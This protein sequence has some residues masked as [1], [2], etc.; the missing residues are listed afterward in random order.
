VI[1]IDFS[2]IIIDFLVMAKKIIS[3]TLLMSILV[4][5]NG[6]ISFHDSHRK[7]LYQYIKAASVEILVDGHLEGSGWFANPD[8]YVTTAAHAVNRTNTSIEIISGNKGRLPA[9]VIASDRGHDIALLKV[10]GGTG[11]FQFLK[12]ADSIPAPED[13]VYLYGSALFH[14]GIMLGG[15]VARDGTTFTYYTDRQMLVRCYHVTA[16]SPPGTSGGPWVDRRG[17]VVGNQ[18][19]FITHHGSGAGIALVAPPDAIVRLV[20]TRKSVSTPSLGCGLEELWTQSPGFIKR[21]PK[22]FM[23]QLTKEEFET[24]CSSLGIAN[25]TTVAANN[26]QILRINSRQ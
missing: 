17:R 24:L 18:S 12:I 6:C 7:N 14:H 19:G 23:F 11:P 20:T 13:P 9:E 15:I 16:P 3:G 26:V 2:L 5:F 25:D 8:G 22:D 21:F 1:T 4:L 10:K